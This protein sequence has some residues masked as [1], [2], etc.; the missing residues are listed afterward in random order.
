M[1]CHFKATLRGNKQFLREYEISGSVS[2]YEFHNFLVGDLAFAPDQ[3][4][5]FRAADKDGVVRSEYGLFDMGDGT[6]DQIT[7]DEC[8]E[9]GEV[10]FEYVYDVFNKRSLVL[11]FTGK[12]EE[13]PKETYPCLVSERGTR[14]DQF[15]SE[16]DKDEE[17]HATGKPSPDD[18]DDDDDL[19]DIPEPEEEEDDED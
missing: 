8:L 17:Y 15:S 6:I 1:V 13:S 11:E 19:D 12:V 16:H 4:V 5:I 7:I 2:L 3:L 14:P 9:K 18:D 10:L